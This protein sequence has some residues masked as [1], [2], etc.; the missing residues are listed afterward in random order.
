MKGIVFDLLEEIVVREH[1]EETWD[2]LLER[3]GLD[4]AYTSLGNYPD[5]EL[6]AL[7]AAASDAL[8]LPPRDIVRWYGRNAMPL[9]AER[10]PAL[11][12]PHSDARSF[13]LTL[14]EII[15]PEV[16]KLYPGADTPTFEFD[17]SQPGHLTMEYHSK[18]K[19]C[20]FAEG[21]LHGAGD[22]YGQR[23]HIEQP[24]CMDRGD[25]RCLIEIAFSSS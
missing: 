13:V 21:L 24:E 3:S 16:R 2:L 9:F 6:A 5:A 7:V 25:R 23:L 18:R 19:L 4:G 17:A 8:G 15:H 12:S 11:F 22:F 1:G 10:Y 14:N 20:A